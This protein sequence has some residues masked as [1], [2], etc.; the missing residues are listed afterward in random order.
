MK[1]KINLLISAVALCCTILLLNVQQVSAQSPNK[2][3]QA[4]IAANR[5]GQAYSITVEK[6]RSLGNSAFEI[7]LNMDSITRAL[8]NIDTKELGEKEWKQPWIDQLD[9]LQVSKGGLTDAV[10][11]LGSRGLAS[12]GKI[13]LTRF[14][15][16]VSRLKSMSS[17]M[18]QRWSTASNQIQT[19]VSNLVLV[20]LL[21]AHDSLFVGSDSLALT[22]R[23][24]RELKRFQS[25]PTEVISA[26][27]TALT[28]KFKP[29][30]TGQS[31]PN[32]WS[33]IPPAIDTAFELLLVDSLFIRDVFV[34]E[35]FDKALPLA[36]TLLSTRTDK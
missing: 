1:P 7:A 3:A 33:G 9:R 24:Q 13:T 15:V 21:V 25:I 29:E 6:I 28:R 27:A 2:I 20:G 35:R 18:V 10:S 19:G 16:Y 34:K 8:I 31:V 32:G 26:W 22:V 12:N 11:I 17:E 30:Y 14:T 5:T 4:M 23:E 36:K